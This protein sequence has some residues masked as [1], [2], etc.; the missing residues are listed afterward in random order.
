MQRYQTIE[1]IE[2]HLL[3]LGCT[4]EQAERHIKPLRA[5]RLRYCPE[6][7]AKTARQGRAVMVCR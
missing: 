5:R 1:G 4:K 6:G 2:Q 3:K 7:S